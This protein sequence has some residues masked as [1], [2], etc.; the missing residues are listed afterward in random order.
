MPEGDPAS[1]V[2]PPAPEARPEIREDV[3]IELPEYTPQI[4]P[5]DYRCFI[6]R[7]PELT[8]RFVTGFGFAPGQP[9]LVH[10]IIIFHAP[11][12]DAAL[13]QAMDDEDPGPGY[14]CYGGP[15]RTG[16]EARVRPG[17]WAAW[18]P[19]VGREPYAEGTGIPAPPGT[20]LIAQV[21]YN[22]G[23][24]EPAADRSH[25]MFQ[26]DD[27]V[28]HPAIFQLMSNPAWLA[29]GGMLI[30]AGEAE[31]QHST[32]VEPGPFIDA[33]TG[34]VEGLDTTGPLLLHSVGMHMHKLGK[35]GS[36]EVVRAGGDTECLLQIPRWDFN[37]QKEFRLQTPLRLERGD[38]VR[39]TCMFDNSAAHQPFV[40]GTQAEPTDVEWGEGTQDEMCLSIV[41][42]TS[43]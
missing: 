21:H 39:L 6:V 14:T 5:D 25:I 34:G 8:D 19:G 32:D 12:E 37:W 33:L 13:F 24:A 40:G 18:A 9:E 31:V 10:H 38:K 7:W 36:L 23:A 20:V 29:P 35:S 4:R 27:A 16:S 41:Y 11:A 43:P 1:F 30:P 2:P 3:V 42:I 15:T 26:V 22:T 17:Q 28:A